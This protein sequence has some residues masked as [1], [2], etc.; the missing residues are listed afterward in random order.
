[1]TTLSTA[2]TQLSLKLCPSLTI[3]AHTYWQLVKC[4]IQHSCWGEFVSTQEG[5]WILASEL[6]LLRLPNSFQRHTPGR[7]S[8]PLW[9]RFVKMSPLIWTEG[10]MSFPPLLQFMQTRC[11][12]FHLCRKVSELSAKSLA[13]LSGRRVRVSLTY[14]STNP[15]ACDYVTGLAAKV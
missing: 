8:D 14:F 4:H 9:A 5:V 6:W 15:N 11:V 12:R 2:Q 13:K 3:I 10:C 1:M 7:E